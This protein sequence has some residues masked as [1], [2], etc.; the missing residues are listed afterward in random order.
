M[1]KLMLL[2]VAGLMALPV[3]AWAQPNR[4]DTCFMGLF[5]D[6]QLNQNFGDV[7]SGTPKD[8]YLGLILDEATETGFTG[9]EFSI[10]GM[11]QA[12]DGILVLS[13][14]ALTTDPPA[15][16]IGSIPAPADTSSTSTSTGGINI[17][18]A[19][20]QQ[21]GAVLKI[22]ILTFGT[23]SNKVFKILRKYPPASP[24][25][26]NPSFFRCDFPVFTQVAIP[27]GCYIANWDGVTDPVELC[28]PH[29]AVT[30]STWAGMKQLYR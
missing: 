25:Y 16:T 21:P 13:A 27:A 18:W 5:D 11:R 6:V 17:A 4:C 2:I 10:Y 3:L 29:V 15:A 8:I 20:C 12:E 7:A 24:N 26:P 9:L 28:A 22:Q 19:T 14:D 23:L 30:R 1:K